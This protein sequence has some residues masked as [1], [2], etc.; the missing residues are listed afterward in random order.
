MKGF[1]LAAMKTR[2]RGTPAVLCCDGGVDD[3]WLIA[4]LVALDVDL[5]CV[6]ATY[7]NTSVEN[8]AANTV[9]LLTLAGR[10]DIPVIRG[11]AR[12]MLPN[13]VQ[14]G[15]RFGGENGFMN[16]PLPP[17]RNPVL[18]GSEDEW[19][20]ALASFLPQ[21]QVL[22]FVS[23]GPATTAAILERKR[24]GTYG[25]SVSQTHIM[26]CAPYGVGCVGN[27]R[28][29]ERYGCAEYN[30]FLDPVAMETLLH[31][32]T[33][34]G[35]ST[36]VVTFESRGVLLEKSLAHKLRASTPVGEALLAATR[37]FFSLYADD[38]F[39]SG[40]DEPVYGV[41]DLPLAFTLDPEFG[42]YTREQI[43]IK[44][45]GDWYGETRTGTSGTAV[46]VYDPPPNGEVVSLA[47]E[48]LG[49]TAK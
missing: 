26:G 34:W 15:S 45:E 5:K 44:T 35:R 23:S 43:V 21:D 25:R 49:M 39:A 37:E 9:S 28:P 46:D 12:P 10:E 16:V 24:S 27:V 2:I 31:L 4:A 48:L 40:R 30:T 1:D 20:A 29:G 22:A 32:G 14:N 17:G 38:N 8:A 41:F 13:P 3:G 42:S 6:V 7:G 47:L 33:R 19:L 18:G 36:R 11:P